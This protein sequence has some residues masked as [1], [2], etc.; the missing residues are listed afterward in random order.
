[1]TKYQGDTLLLRRYDLDNYIH[2][3]LLIFKGNLPDQTGP[4]TGPQPDLTGPP[5]DQTGPLPA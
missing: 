2:K 1:M 5:P 3:K 4:I